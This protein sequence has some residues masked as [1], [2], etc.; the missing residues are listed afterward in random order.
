MP[1]DY[2]DG[3]R[4]RVTVP[5]TEPL[6]LGEWRSIDV[7]CPSLI[8]PAVASHEC[9]EIQY[10][11]FPYVIYAHHGKRWDELGEQALQM[12]HGSIFLPKPGEWWIKAEAL[13]ETESTS[14]L[15]RIYDAN[16]P[17]AARYVER[18][19]LAPVNE[20]IVEVSYTSTL[21]LAANA[22]RRYLF[23][24]N[25]TL[26]GEDEPDPDMVITVRPYQDA[27][28]YM[29]WSLPGFGSNHERDE[30]LGDKMPLGDI[31]A[32]TPAGTGLLY[33]MEGE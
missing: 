11:P 4:P 26:D 7:N 32:I 13:I 3:E 23:F 22:R 28:A 5:V 25:V 18:K 9:P 27:V 8:V 2:I 24:Q 12:Q 1:H 10:A 16:D 30:S 31:Y 15:V 33:M 17:S 20:D 19:I 14:L 21:V 29:G 6:P